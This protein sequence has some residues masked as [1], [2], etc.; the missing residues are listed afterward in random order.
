MSGQSSAS[1]CLLRCFIG[2]ALKH[3]QAEAKPGGHT[4]P[5]KQGA[6]KGIRMFVWL[7]CSF[8]IVC[9]LTGYDMRQISLL[10]LIPLAFVKTAFTEMQS[11]CVLQPDC[12][13]PLSGRSNKGFTSPNFTVE[14]K[15]SKA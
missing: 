3:N 11:G 7:S 14:N 15:D 12:N 9:C 6:D 4:A 1:Q 5:W 8:S 10:P 13:F 2:L